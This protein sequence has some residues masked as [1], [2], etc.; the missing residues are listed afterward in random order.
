MGC[1]SSKPQFERTELSS[2]RGEEELLGAGAAGAALEL[3][4]LVEQV[5]NNTL[6]E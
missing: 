6:A 5:L 2:S 4:D 3:F 1:A